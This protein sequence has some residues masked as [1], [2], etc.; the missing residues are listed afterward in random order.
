MAAPAGASDDGR[1]RSRVE[2]LLIGRS[3]AV[4]GVYLRIAVALAVGQAVFTV[5]LAVLVDQYGLL[6]RNL[7]AF[8][9]T[10]VLAG[11]LAAI[12]N[13]AR[14]GGLLVS[15]SLAVAPLIGAVPVT[16]LRVG[17]VDE[18]VV[19]TGFMVGGLGVWAGVLGFALGV[20]GTRV[21]DRISRPR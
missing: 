19:A 9:L 15:I 7:L 10:V 21:G 4:A 18:S 2:R 5:A 1:D 14:K 8:A 17:R 3:D 13:G 20:A 6:E 11:L 12:V 16:L